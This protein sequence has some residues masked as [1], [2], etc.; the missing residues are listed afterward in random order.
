MNVRFQAVILEEQLSNIKEKKVASLY[1]SYESDSHPTIHPNVTICIL[2]KK[3]LPV[4]PP[5]GRICL[6]V[7]FADGLN[8]FY[9]SY[10]ERKF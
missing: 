4:S 1:F 3:I 9:R 5:T 6:S 10:D 2:K 8:L 7:S